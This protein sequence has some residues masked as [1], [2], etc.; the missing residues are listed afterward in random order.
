MS[1]VIMQ[2]RLALSSSTQRINR[3]TVDVL[4]HTHIQTHTQTQTHKHTHTL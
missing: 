1:P 3:A 2:V 4:E